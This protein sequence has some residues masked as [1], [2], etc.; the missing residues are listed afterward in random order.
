M[1]QAWRPDLYQKRRAPLRVRQTVMR[2]VRATFDSMGFAEV[3]TPALQ[4]SPGNEVHL[5]AFKTEL[6]DP[7]GGPG[8]CLY[9]HTSPEFSMKKLLVAGEP[10]I[11]QI[12]HTY[13]NGERSSRH[14]PEFTMIEW[15]RA[16]ADTAAIKEDCVTLVRACATAAGKKIFHANGMACDPFVAWETLSVPDAFRRY[17]GIDLLATT[18]DPHKP[19]A[20]LLRE[21]MKPLDIRT[22]PDDSWDDLFFRVMGELIEPFLG[23]DRPTFLCDYPLSMAAL[24]RPLPDDPRLA[25]RFELYIAGYEI[26]N[27]FGELTDADEQLRRFQADMDLKEEIHGERYPIDMDFIDALRYG[28][29]P[30][31]GIALGIDRL[32][33]LCAGVEEIEDVLWLPVWRRA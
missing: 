2:T 27:A 3:D 31:A 4:F 12:A 13:R 23:K 6:R 26:A 8:Q 15:Y 28:M 18:P 9:L 19:D 25:E 20:A 14:H 33:M 24:A 10:L 1:V 5:Q 16:Q 7:H 30:A 29:P 22:A 21:A 17:A 32:V 11:Y